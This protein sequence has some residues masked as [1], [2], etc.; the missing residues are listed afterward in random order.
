MDYSKERN[1]VMRTKGADKG[2]REGQD[3]LKAE[4]PR[5]YRGT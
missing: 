2:I 4:F 1:K 3:L 5:E